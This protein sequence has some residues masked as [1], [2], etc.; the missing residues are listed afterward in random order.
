[1]YTESLYFGQWSGVIHIEFFWRFYIG[2]VI[3]HLDYIIKIT[4]KQ[5]IVITRY[6]F[7]FTN[8]LVETIAWHLARLH[9]IE[10]ECCGTEK[11][12]LCV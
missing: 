6:K 1:M 9:D 5:P 8:P 12:Y 11:R 4:K 7:L 10:S 3:F 2:S